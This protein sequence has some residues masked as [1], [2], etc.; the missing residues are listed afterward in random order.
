MVTLVNGAIVKSGHG[1][2]YRNSIWYR[3]SGTK[4]R[5]ETAREDAEQGDVNRVYVN[6]DEY[7]GG[8][9]TK[10]LETYR[11]DEIM[12]GDAAKFGHGGSDFWSMYY[13]VE[14]IKGSKDVDVID[15][16]EAVDMAMVGHFAYRSILAGGVPMEIPN[17]KNVEER[18]KWR[19]DVACC[20]YEVAGKDVWPTRKGGTPKISKEVYE[21]QNKLFQEDLKSDSGYSN[22]AFNQGK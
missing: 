18:N 6:Y 19:N 5:I 10:K 16:Y 2:T 15:V 13:F 4:G 11:A 3:I 14:K 17:L 21:Y 7:P 20:Y 8:Y 22:E 9:S 12:K 1:G